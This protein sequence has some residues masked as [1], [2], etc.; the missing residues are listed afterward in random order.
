MNKNSE[1][2]DNKVD[3]F[4]HTC[5]FHDLS[6][7]LQRLVFFS[8]LVLIQFKTHTV[9]SRQVVA[10][11]HHIRELFAYKTIFAILGWF[12]ASVEPFP[13]IKR[14]QRLGVDFPKRRQVDCWVLAESDILNDVGVDRGD[15]FVSEHWNRAVA[16]F[17]N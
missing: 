15:I 17:R 16:Y 8:K 7:N 10:R 3:I 12:A 9:V 11:K 2:F 6:T 14:P 13:I 1:I 5:I 4:I